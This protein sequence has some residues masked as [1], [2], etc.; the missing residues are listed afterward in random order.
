MQSA[1]GVSKGDDTADEAQAAKATSDM[2]AVSLGVDV[3]PAQDLHS[4]HLATS[5]LITIYQ[6]YNSFLEQGVDVDSA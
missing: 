5:K 2:L 1:L 6:S 3:D 4:P